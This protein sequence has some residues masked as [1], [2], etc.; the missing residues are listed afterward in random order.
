MSSNNSALEEFL[1]Q[2][3]EISERRAKKVAS[4]DLVKWSIKDVDTILRQ[5]HWASKARGNRDPC[6]PEFNIFT[7]WPWRLRA[8]AGLLVVGAIGLLLP[9]QVAGLVSLGLRRQFGKIWRELPVPT[10]VLWQSWG[11]DMF[12]FL[13][14]PIHVVRE[15]IQQRAA[16][17]VNARGRFKVLKNGYTVMSHVWA[18]TMG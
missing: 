13:K 7:E 16:L 1:T 6:G 3:H 14:T 2:T 12:R 11:I 18:E 8:L 9:L 4:S 15:S 10:F 17:C 5:I